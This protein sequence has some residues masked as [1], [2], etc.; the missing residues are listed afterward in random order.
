MV[1]TFQPITDNQWE[2]IDPLFVKEV[3]RSRGKPHAPW[4]NVLNS[5][6]FVLL[7]GNKWSALPLD[8]SYAP[9]SVAH[10]W[11]A[12]WDK[13]GFLQTL[14]HA[15]RGKVEQDVKILSPRRRNRLPATKSLLCTQTT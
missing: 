4:R 13:N 14:I 11:F 3:K 6:L 7:T 2:Q 12:I 1:T 15:Y 5:I 9:K 8:P 10:R